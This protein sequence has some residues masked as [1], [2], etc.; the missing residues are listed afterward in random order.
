[1]SGDSKDQR[2]DVRLDPTPNPEAKM[3]DDTFTAD[4]PNREKLS[5]DEVAEAAERA[6]ED[7]PVTRREIR[8]QSA[9]KND[10]ADVG[11]RAADSERAKSETND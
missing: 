2:D 3:T 8:E 1:M 9:Y 6:T 5:G 4:A 11:Q 7:E 10:S